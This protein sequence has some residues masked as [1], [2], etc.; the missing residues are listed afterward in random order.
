M[1]DPRPDFDA[2][3]RLDLGST[4]SAAGPDVLIWLNGDLRSCAL[5]LSLLGFLAEIGLNPQ[6]IA[7]EYNG[8]ILSRQQWGETL[9]AA[10]DVLEIVTIVGGG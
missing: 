8:E 2:A 5:G 1:L 6:L 9:L 10:D 3:N 4:A 7:I